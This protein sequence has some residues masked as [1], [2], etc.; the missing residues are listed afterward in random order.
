MYCSLEKKQRLLGHEGGFMGEDDEIVIDNL[1]GKR[2]VW[3]SGNRSW[4]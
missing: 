4:D 1:D 2:E 3:A